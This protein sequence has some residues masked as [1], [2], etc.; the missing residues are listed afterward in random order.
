MTILDII[1]KKRDGYELSKEEID[2]FIKGL[3][4]GEI[5]DYQV[6]A[7]LMA[8]YFNGMTDDEITN[9]TISMADSGEKVDLSDIEGIKADKHS[10]GGVGDTT[11]LIAA[12]IAASCGAIIAKMSGRGLS[13][14]GGTLD[15][16][17]S[18]PGVSISKSIDELKNIVRSNG[19]CVVGQTK[20]LVPA[21]KLLYSLRDVTGTVD[22]IPLIA[23]S[24]MSKK[25]ASGADVI[26]IDVKVGNG[27][28]MSDVS[29]A[30]KLAQTMVSIGRNNGKKVVAVLSD[31]NSPLGKNIGNA[32][33]VK[34]A[35]DVLSGKVDVSDRLVYVSLVIAGYIIFLSGNAKC[36]DEAFDMAKNALFS[37]KALEKFENMLMYL[38]ADKKDID[39]ID[40]FIKTEN[41][42][43]IKAE[44]TG[45]VNAI[46]A[47][48]IGIASLKLGAGREK[49][50]DNIDHA[51]GIVLNC[52]VGD[53]VNK[54]DTLAFINYNNK[55]NIRIAEELVKT[56]MIIEDDR[57]EDIPLIYK[58]IGG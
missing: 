51:V 8:I 25:L 17:E 14:S 58:I 1:I 44:K 53:K 3:V 2:F 55:E 56:A 24:V 16:L 50:D 37:G 52:R 46:Y 19:V 27:A 22:S 9:L 36:F 7:L 31:M 39:N 28:F 40:N 43:E 54:G 10:T 35:L 42:L 12:P 18:L 20:N 32:L 47:K 26:V 29:K 13:F 33:E 6:S 4:N 49:K 5:P 48:N 11:T 34:E 41:T 38:G 57:A 23:S 45:Y 30:E 15:K 21:D